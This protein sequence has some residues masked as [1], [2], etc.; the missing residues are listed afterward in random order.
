MKKLLFAVA[1]L[2]CLPLTAGAE[3]GPSLEEVSAPAA[4]A[5][6]T[7]GAASGDVE[8]DGVKGDND[9]TCSAESEVGYPFP[10]VLDLAMESNFD[11]S[12]AVPCADSSQDCPCSGSACR[13]VY[14]AGCGMNICLCRDY[15][16]G[17]D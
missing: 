12:Q 9:Y 16:W 15:C 4:T 3:M 11:C 14:S 8:T 2:L 10:S 17:G 1:F 6:A 13:C 7:T 5:V